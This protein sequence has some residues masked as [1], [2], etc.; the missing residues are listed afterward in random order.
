MK[1]PFHSLIYIK[2]IFEMT[3]KHLNAKLIC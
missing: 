1:V 2:V 3:R